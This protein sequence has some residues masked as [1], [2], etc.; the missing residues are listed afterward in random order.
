[1][2]PNEI[3]LNYELAEEMVRIFKQSVEQLQDTMQEMQSVANTLEEGA[4]LGRG[5]AMF[6]DAIRGRLC[7]SI[8]RLTEKFE[9]LAGDVNVAINEMREADQETSGKFS[10]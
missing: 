4:L 3:K 5:G 6:T 2:E 9:E 8:S 10:G 7:P 1:M